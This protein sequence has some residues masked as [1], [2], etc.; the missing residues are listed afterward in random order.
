MQRGIGESKMTSTLSGVPR[1][2]KW[3]DFRA[4]TT[5]PGGVPFGAET[6]VT[7][8]VSGLHPVKVQA[9]RTDLFLLPDSITV[10]VTLATDS[11]RL[12]SLEN[13]KWLLRHEQGHYDVYA[14]MIRDWFTDV[15]AMIP[16]PWAMNDLNEQLH[17]LKETYLDRI[18][19][20]QNSYDSDTEH[21]QNGEDQWVWWS[22]IRRA[23]ELHRM[24]LTPGPDGRLLKLRLLDALRTANLIT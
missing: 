4:V 19:S 17:D 24:P 10:S 13:D 9:S 18:T 15:V 16:Q 7:H 1:T 5:A 12:T 6:V 23:M 11:W 22:V 14:L 21:D 2:L 8:H 3:S 20:I